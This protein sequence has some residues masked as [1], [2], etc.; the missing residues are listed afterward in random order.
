[1]HSENTST[2]YF[3]NL[4]RTYEVLQEVKTTNLKHREQQSLEIYFTQINYF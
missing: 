3:Q 4:E 2:K 1:M